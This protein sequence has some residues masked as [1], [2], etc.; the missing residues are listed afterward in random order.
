MSKFFGNRLLNADPF[1]TRSYM[2]PPPEGDGKGEKGKEGEGDKGKGGGGPDLKAINERLEKLEKENAD[3]KKSAGGKKDDDPDLEAKAKASREAKE[4]SSSDTK[5][6]EAALKFSLGAKD[7]LKQNASLLPKDIEGIF[8]EADK[9]K[10]DN[11]IEKDSAIKAS[12]VQSFF[13]V[14]SNLDLLTPSQKTILED[15]LKLTKNGKQEKA[16]N[17][18]ETVFEPTFEMF[19]RVKKAEQLGKDGQVEASDT[20]QAYS[21]RMMKLSKKHYMGEKVN[22]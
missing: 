14:Q 10:Y 5:K 17:L 16:Q 3:L 20:I 13:N 21:D 4:K 2:C 6:I 9:E 7:F 12:L 18:Y 15:F 11:A 19:K 22:E 1:F 8:A